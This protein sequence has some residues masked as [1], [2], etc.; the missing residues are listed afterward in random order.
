[1]EGAMEE[2]NDNAEKVVAVDTAKELLNSSC[3]SCC[4]YLLWDTF[5]RLVD[6]LVAVPTSVV[7]AA[8][9]ASL[10]SL[11]LALLFR[12]GHFRI[13]TAIVYRCHACFESCPGAFSGPPGRPNA[14]KN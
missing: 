2:E 4:C 11:L 7:E 6:P 1:M 13:K 10:F 3:C 8:D 5:Q 9:G 12:S 14:R